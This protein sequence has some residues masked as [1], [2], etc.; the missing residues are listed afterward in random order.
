[1]KKEESNNIHLIK[2]YWDL[3]H[4]YR[5]RF[6][7]IIALSFMR[8]VIPLT[9]PWMTKILIDQVLIGNSTVWTLQKVIVVLVVVY[10]VGNAV[11]FIRDYYTSIV[12]TQ[13]MIDVRRKLYQH[14]QSLSPRF[15]DSQQVGQLVSRLMTDVSSAQNL[16]SGGIL[17]ILVDFMLI[18]ISSVMLLSLN[19][20]LALLSLALLP[21]LYLVFTNTNLRIRM[22][23]R[24]VKQQM[25][26]ITATLVE[27]IGAIKIV[28]SFN[29]EQNELDRYDAK[30]KNLYRYT[31][32]AQLMSNLLGKLTQSFN[33]MGNVLIWFV[34]GWFVLQHHLT[35]GALVAF[36]AY[37]NQLYS[38]VKRFTSINVTI[39]NSLTSVERIFQ[40][41]DFE[42]DI[43]NIS[44]PHHITCCKGELEF[45]HVKFSYR[46]VPSLSTA[47]G[48]K[49]PKNESKRIYFLP[50]KM[51][52]PVVEDVS[53]TVETALED[54]SFHIHP[55]E[56]V[57]LVGPSGAGK[58]TLIQLVNRFYDPDQGEILLDGVNLKHY[59]LQD[60]RA[61]IAMVW[62]DNVLFS[63][64]IRDNI[65]YGKPEAS[66][67]EIVEA[68]KAANA[69]AFIESFTD[70]YDTL[71]GERGLRL[72]GGQKQR[73]AIARALLLD[74]KMLILDE[75]TSAL[76]AESEWL[77][78]E[79]LERL[80]NNRTTIIIAHRL[81]T[82][83]RADQIVVMDQGRIVETGSHAQLMQTSKLYHSLYEK[84]YKA[85]RPEFYQD[86]LYT[87]SL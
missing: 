36:Q 42:P 49:M 53:M 10:L 83:V 73:I 32:S 87:T 64:T 30:A 67:E 37:L 57:A 48:M 80:M 24:R 62:Q 4:P 11:N 58:S 85:M 29:Q 40:V 2:R 74:P 81:A 60:L 19:W 47:K 54:I 79:A 39:Q 84:Q 82:V 41:L 13:I 44:V 1:M 34:G 72:S 35:V 86:E 77:V 33:Q 45:T 12:G 59:D 18:I 55:G 7:I 9:V 8:F 75:A 14:L 3:I 52:R 68:A 25:S 26:D 78:T 65:S 56:V 51:R 76:D 61:Q 66:M 16:V 70:G 22:Y 43:Q 20:K 28:Q 17:G 6:M 50:P 38:P 63:G 21:L 5:F 31:L 69:H 71:L 27:R 15:Y 23:G 46:S